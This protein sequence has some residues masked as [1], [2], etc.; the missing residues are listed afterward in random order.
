MTACGVTML[1]TYSMGFFLGLLC[2][3]VGWGRKLRE[4]RNICKTIDQLKRH[5]EQSGNPWM[6]P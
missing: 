2:G 3:W 1:A 6:T 4:I 5:D